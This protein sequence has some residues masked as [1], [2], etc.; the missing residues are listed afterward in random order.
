MATEASVDTASLKVVS[1]GDTGQL[2]IESSTG[3]VFNNSGYSVTGQPENR[4]YVEGNRV[5]LWSK[6]WIRL[7]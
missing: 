4:P 2:V 6:P 7:V 5:W 3:V 1:Y